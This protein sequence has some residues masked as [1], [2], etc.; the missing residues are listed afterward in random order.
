MTTEGW[1]TADIQKVFRFRERGKN[2]QPLY[3]AE[4]RG[5]IP[6]AMRVQRGQV[7]VRVW[8]PA[9]WPAI[10]ERFGFLGPVIKPEVICVYTAKGGV[11]KTTTAYTLARILAL[12]GKKVLIVGLD[13]QCSI[14]DIVMPLPDVE[15]LEDLPSKK[16]RGLY[17]FFHE[18]QK[19]EDVIQKTDL[20][21]LDIIPENARLNL[22]DK[23]MR[24]ETRRES[25]FSRDLKPLLLSKTKGLGYDV[26]IFDNGPSWNLLIENALCAAD[27][28][29]SPIGCDVGTYQALRTNME[30][31]SDFALSMELEWDRFLLLPTLLDNTK[32]SHQIYGA[33]LQQYSKFM[34]TTPIRRAVKGQEALFCKKTVLEYDSKSPVA[35]DYYEMIKGLWAKITGKSTRSHAA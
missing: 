29:L 10:G 22:L 4:E 26:V 20:P 31:V 12:H 2:M 28:V 13:I 32:L 9:D 34:I 23:R 14:T 16:R 24:S 6:K 7:S 1:T 35:A 25:I 17:E 15:S 8:P 21:T 3:H 27:T 19:L 11:L 33:Y 30:A 5:L 18:G